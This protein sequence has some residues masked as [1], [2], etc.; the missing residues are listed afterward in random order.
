[1]TMS[2][3]C[4]ESEEQAMMKG[5]GIRYERGTREFW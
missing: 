4:A 1:M 5:E 2:A 3:V